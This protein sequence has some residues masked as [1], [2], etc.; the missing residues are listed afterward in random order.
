MRF[1][2]LDDDDEFRF[3]LSHHSGSVLLILTAPPDS[4]AS[5]RRRYRDTYAFMQLLMINLL[6]APSVYGET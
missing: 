6:F 3:R 2:S 4:F 5:F 1:I